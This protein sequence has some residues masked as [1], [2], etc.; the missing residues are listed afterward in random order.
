[1]L[2]MYIRCLKCCADKSKEVLSHMLQA[3]GVFLILDVI[4]M[5]LLLNLEAFA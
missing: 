1:M 5:I 4:K 2:F 3:F